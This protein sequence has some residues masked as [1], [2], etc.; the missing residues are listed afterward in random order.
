[1][2]LRDAFTEVPTQKINKLY[3]STLPNKMDN[4]LQ[5]LF[6]NPLNNGWKLYDLI[7]FIYK[8]SING[9]SHKLYPYLLNRYANGDYSKN[10][11]LPYVDLDCKRHMIRDIIV[12]ADPND[13]ERLANK[14]IKKMPNLETQFHDSIISTTD[15]E[16]W[17]NQR[18]NLI[19][20]FN[21]ETSLE[22]I[23]PISN[24]RAK[25]CKD[26]IWE[27]CQLN[28][29]NMININDFFLNETQAQLQMS[30]FGFS[31][32]Y[33][34]KTNKKIRDA[35]D[36]IGV[37]NARKYAV[38]SMYELKVADGP[39]SRCLKEK[40]QMTD[41][42]LYGNMLLFLFAGHDTTGNTLTWLLYELAKN[43][44]TQKQ[45]QNEVD[46]FWKQQGESEIK[47]NDF[48]RLPFMTRCIMETLRLWTPVP[49][50]TFRELMSDDIITGKNGEKVEVRKGTYIQIVNWV[51]HRD[52]K[53]WGDDVNIFNPNRDFKKNEIWNNSVY[54]FSNPNSK[55]FS[56]FSYEP[57]DCLGKNFAQMEMR[58]M[59]LYL[60][61]DYNFTLSNK[62]AMVAFDEHNLD[63]NFGTLTPKDIY[64]PKNDLCP[65]LRKYNHGLYLCVNKRNISSRL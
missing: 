26:L 27:K 7:E 56:P 14:H 33:Q 9:L 23:M 55:R 17:N 2:T 6:I 43:I 4:G 54:H 13:A 46:I 31:G 57:R 32:K 34:E 22:K 51:R 44:E 18:K 21:P 59:L 10:I 49:N 40:K 60:L 53:L 47:L 50:G 61:K 5:E 24:N 45:L 19:E 42:E 1:M 65:E 29:N 25:K 37:G 58:L 11:L 35:F 41:S 3:I 30:L 12:I 63:I 62:Q 38:S 48:K 20:A 28:E 36:S 39:L 15:I 8:N 52:R 64:K 16:H